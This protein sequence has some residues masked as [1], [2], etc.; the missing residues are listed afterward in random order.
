MKIIKDAKSFFL[1]VLGPKARFDQYVKRLDSCLSCS[2]NVEKN[3]LN[4]CRGCACPQ[5]KLWPW[6]ELKRK[7]TYTN[8][9]CP[10]KKWDV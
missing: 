1:A 6:A 10:R 7:A 8:T 2:W 5:T 3:K 4:Y 9:V